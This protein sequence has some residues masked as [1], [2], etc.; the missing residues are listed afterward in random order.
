MAYFPLFSQEIEEMGLLDVSLQQATKVLL[1]CRKTLFY[2]YA[3]AYFLSEDEDRW[4]E[5]ELFESQQLDLESHTE[6]LSRLFYDNIVCEASKD[7]LINNTLI[8]LISRSESGAEDPLEPLSLNLEKGNAHGS[9]IKGI[10]MGSMAALSNQTAACKQYLDNLLNET[11]QDAIK[12]LDK[13][14][15]SQCVISA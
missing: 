12:L 4:Q 5:L 3:H 13:G 2:T 6:R 7:G 11:N 8:S 15:C 9:D 14:I 1:S 10:Y